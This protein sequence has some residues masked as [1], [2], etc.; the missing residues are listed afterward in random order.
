MASAHM[1]Y[2]PAAGRDWALPLYDPLVKLL[3]ADALR[4]EL[5]AA[6]AL[7]PGH[8]VLDVGCGTGTLAIAIKRQ[9]PD[10]DVTG[11]DPDPK[12]LARARRK[13][14]RAGASVCLDTGFGDQLP[15]AD[16]AF[17]R[18]F[19]SFMF[20]HVPTES[21][22]PMLREVRRVLKPGGSLHLVDFTTP[23]HGHDG[24]MAR[25]HPSHHLDGNTDTRL[26]SLMER[27]GFRAVSRKREGSMLF[28]L[29][30]FAFY[31]AL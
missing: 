19:S 17:D 15:Y 22:E 20:H 27:A 5:I 12:A 1:T 29:L 18:V 30:R 11:L 31:E 2:L 24:L 3:G 28:G 16:A 23:E 9:H 14:D 21:R 25:L 26:R 8:R 4:A 7:R 13:A 6:A 10:V